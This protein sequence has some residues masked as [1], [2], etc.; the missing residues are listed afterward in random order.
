[1]ITRIQ[2]E[3]NKSEGWQ[4][5]MGKDL[6]AATLRAGY[7]ISTKFEKVDN[8]FQEFFQRTGVSLIQSEAHTPKDLM[9]GA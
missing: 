4:I 5:I 6:N 1:M 7:S 8:Q 3:M 2:A 9:G